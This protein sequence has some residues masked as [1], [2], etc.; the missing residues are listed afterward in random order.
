[1]EDPEACQALADYLEA[2]LPKDGGRLY[3]P[4]GDI[5]SLQEMVDHIRSGTPQGLRWLEAQRNLQERLEKNH[6]EA[7]IKFLRE[8]EEMPEGFA[9]LVGDR[10]L[11][12]DDII[13]EVEEGT[14]IG[15]ELAESFAEDQA[16]L[17]QA[18]AQLGSRIKRF[19]KKLHPARVLK[20][21]R[22]QSDF[23]SNQYGE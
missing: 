12:R 11:E 23:Y 21:V 8:G 13:R 19:L 15:I 22:R 7:F 18:E 4:S 5:M 3:S 20:G 17:R 16:E 10:R 6:R 2:D 1:M 9:L 14:E